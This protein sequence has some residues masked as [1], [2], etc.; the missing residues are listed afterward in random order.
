VTTQHKSTSLRKLVIAL[1]VL[2]GVAAAIGIIGAFTYT[3][4]SYRRVVGARKITM[5]HIFNGTFYAQ[6]Y[7]LNWVPEGSL[8]ISCLPPTETHSLV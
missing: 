8:S 7:H 3:G 4:A 5:D 6:G 2:V 1:V